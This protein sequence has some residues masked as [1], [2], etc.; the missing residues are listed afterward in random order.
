MHH[1]AWILW[2]AHISSE[3]VATAKVPSHMPGHGHGGSDGENQHWHDHIGGSP[4]KGRPAWGASLDTSEDFVKTV[5]DVY[6][7]VTAGR[8]VSAP[9]LAANLMWKEFLNDR[10]EPIGE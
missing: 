8:L 4:S 6:T 9:L 1:F 7:K 2:H 5:P 10:M 3:I